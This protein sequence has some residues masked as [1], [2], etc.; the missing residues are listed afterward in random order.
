MEKRTL[1]ELVDNIP[2]DGNVIPDLIIER[3]VKEGI[4]NDT[5]QKCCH[6][7]IFYREIERDKRIKEYN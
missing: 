4:G 3:I 5:C 7:G 1:L 6:C 2:L